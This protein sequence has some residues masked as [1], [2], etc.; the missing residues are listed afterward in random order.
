MLYAVFEAHPG[1]PV[2]PTSVLGDFFFGCAS[3]PRTLDPKPNP[4]PW[5]LSP[6]SKALLPPRSARHCNQPLWRAGHWEAAGGV[7][8]QHG[9]MLQRILWVDIRAAPTESYS[10]CFK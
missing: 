8:G 9:E 3:K 1:S 7:L 5:V 6:K 10:E 4:K 2:S